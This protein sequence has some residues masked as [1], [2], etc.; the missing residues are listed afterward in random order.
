MRAQDEFL[1]VAA[2]ELKTPMTGAK[3]AAQLLLRRIAQRGA[4]DPEYLQR[5]LQMI[6]QQIDRLRRLVSKLLETERLQ[7]DQLG[8]KPAPAEVTALLRAAVDQAQARTT[9]HDVA[10]YAPD[11]LWAEVDAARLEQVVTNLLDNALKFSSQGGRIEVMLHCPTAEHL[12]LA[13]RDHG[14]GVPEE[15]RPH[16]FERFYQA[17]ASTHRSGLGLGL[18]IS[19]EIVVRHGGEI[20][21]DFPPDRGTHMV[22]TLPLRSSTAHGDTAE[23]DRMRPAV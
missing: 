14:I 13:V 23:A 18:Y 10:L 1:V 11:E 17:H 9:Q 15:H 19:R 4:A 5:P 3:I 12:E 22:V 8:V 16:L 6:D 21:A 7:A 20:A 2:H